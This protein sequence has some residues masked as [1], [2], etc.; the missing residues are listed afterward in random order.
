MAS[1]SDFRRVS[2]LG[3][4]ILLIVVIWTGDRS[5]AKPAPYNPNE[6][7][8][9]AY[10]RHAHQTGKTSIRVPYPIV[11][12]AELE[13][14]DHALAHTTVVVARLIASET[15]YTKDEITTWRKYA[16]AEKLS[17]QLEI[18]AQHCGEIPS[19]M[20]PLKS[21]EFV[22]PEIGGTVEV[23][24]VRLIQRD[25]TESDIP[26]QDRHLIF[27]LIVCSGSIALPNYGPYGHFSLDD[28]DNV[29]I[30]AISQN[31]PLKDELLERTGGKLSSL[32]SISATIAPRSLQDRR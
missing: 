29:H 28:S 21:E 26:A 19:S 16:I 30:S 25:S 14:L 11:E 32:R 1:V 22:I 7:L 13:D 8:I 24:G 17:R 23:D 31:N 3:A 27:V 15:V 5:G 20:L 9:A 10:V 6:G 2:R 12:W 4:I 18:P